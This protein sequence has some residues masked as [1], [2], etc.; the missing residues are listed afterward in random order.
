FH[1]AGADEIPLPDGS[2]D[3]GYALGVLHHIPDTRQGMADAVAKLKPGAPF[4]VYLYY[5][6][7]F[8]PAWFRA[9][10]RM[11]DLAR[12]GVHRLPIRGRRA[13]TDV[14]AALVYWPL[15]RAARAGEVIGLNIANAPLAAYRRR[16]FYSMRTDALDRFGTRLEHRFTN[17]QIEQMMREAGLVEIRFSARSPYWVACGRKAPA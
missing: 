8:R 15:A 5:A 7:E 11:T 6:L 2:Q 10:W 12:R 13:V 14:I 3:F 17:A 4:L 16:T 9:L 1:L